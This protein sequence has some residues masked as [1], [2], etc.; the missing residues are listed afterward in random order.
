M[1]S[2][3]SDLTEAESRVVVPRARSSEWR[4]AGKSCS[5]GTN[6]SKGGSE[7]LGASTQYS[8]NRYYVLH[9]LKS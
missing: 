8:D 7:V 4:G 1:E 9:I 3:K 2:I 5:M 6:Y